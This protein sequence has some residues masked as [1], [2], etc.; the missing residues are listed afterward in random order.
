VNS[1]ESSALTSAHV[2]FFVHAAV[3]EL[4]KQQMRRLGQIGAFTRRA[5]LV[6]ESSNP[7]WGYLGCVLR[8]TD[9]R[10]VGDPPGPEVIAYG[11]VLLVSD[12]LSAR[13]VELFLLA[14]QQGRTTIAGIDVGFKL[15]PGCEVQHVSVENIWMEQAGHVYSFRSSNPLIQPFQQRLLKQG[16]PY[17]PDVFDAA[18]SWLGLRQYHGSSDGRKGNVIVLVPETRAVISAGVWTSDDELAI[19]IAGPAVGTSKLAVVGAA[20]VGK[21]IVHFEHAVPSD[22]RVSLC[23]PERSDRLEMFVLDSAGETYDFHV[24]NLAGY[25]PSR[26]FLSARH[27]TGRADRVLKA[28]AEGEGLH[29]EFKEFLDLAKPKGP[30]TDKDKFTQVVKCVAAFAN[31]KGGTI[32]LGISDDCEVVGVNEHISKWAQTEL[33]EVAIQNYMGSLRSKLRDRL[34][35]PV[36]IHTAAIYHRDRLVIAL[37]VSKGRVPVSLLD[38]NRLWQRRQSS[39]MSVAPADWAGWNSDLFSF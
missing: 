4:L 22:G 15:L 11:D 6:R 14:L 12:I 18:S 31:T 36:S 25:V 20:W 26:S 30:L 19:H 10:S 38:D 13:D 9:E 32:F 8:P 28:I 1:P 37:D 16:A 5:V 23:L 2:P 7:S 39:N 3:P 29:T 33:D 27:G 17:F 35:S 34:N 24:E 21:S